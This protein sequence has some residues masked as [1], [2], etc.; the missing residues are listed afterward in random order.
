MYKENT[1]KMYEE[2]VKETNKNS[3]KTK[4]FFYSLLEL[5]I[6][7]CQY[8]MIFGL[9]SNG[10][11]TA[12]YVIALIDY[13]LNGNQLALVRRYDIDFKGKSGKEMFKGLVALK[14]K[15]KN[16]IEYLTDG[17]FND[18]RYYSS[19]WFLC[20]YD[21]ELDK[22]VTDSK[23]FCQAFALN[24]SEHDKSVSFPYVRTILFDEFITR[25]SYLPDEFVK[26]M[27]TISTIVR[28]KNETTIFMC[29]NSINKYCPHFKEMGLYNIT[30]MQP[31]SIEYYKYGESKLKVGV[32][33]AGVNENISKDKQKT[34]S[35]P[36]D[37]Y[38][39]FQN[40][41]LQMIT[42]GAWE[43]DIYPHLPCEYKKENV[44]F[45]YFI[46]FEGNTLQCEIIYIDKKLFTFVHKKTSD[47]KYTNKDL[48]YQQEP[49]ANYNISNDIS[50][51]RND[52]EKKIW[53]L[54]CT[55]KT[56]YQDNEVGEI[57]KNYILWCDEH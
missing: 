12:V 31:D 7:I 32:E 3:K 46:K 15:G 34:K 30:K 10:K 57:Y 38:F 41:K 23:P 5:L 8:Y 48:I 21:E 42:T 26:F 13:C 27:N 33:F 29:A 50:Q 14:F 22:T 51:P 37:V 47:I 2:F 35:K 16:L 20:K 53:W 17:K 18:I 44:K 6:E 45:R 54:Y 49:S 56:F 28:E 9:R 24:V 40:P 43:I 11:T 52:V 1:L 25:D 4:V 19:Q 36:S 39:A 55:G